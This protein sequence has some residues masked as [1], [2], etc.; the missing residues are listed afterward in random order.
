[1]AGIREQLRRFATAWLLFQVTTFVAVPLALCNDAPA[2]DLQ[3]CDCPGELSG[4]MCPMHR[5]S[6]DTTAADA[7]AQDI[8]V[9]RSGCAPP[10]ALLLSIFTHA[11]TLPPGIAIAHHPVSVSVPI[12]E[13]TMTIWI[14]VPDSPP[15]R[16]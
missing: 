2:V 11:G 13:S 6:E 14:D 10:D 3:V 4:A 7:S 16:A 15:P 5:G 8:C 1:M 12:P 9:L